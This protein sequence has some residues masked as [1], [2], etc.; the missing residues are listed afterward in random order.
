MNQLHRKPI[1]NTRICLHLAILEHFREC[2]P[3]KDDN[4]MTLNRFETICL[5]EPI[6]KT[7]LPL[8]TMAKN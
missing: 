1:I 5:K 3:L 8:T 2:I 4:V 6:P 7:S